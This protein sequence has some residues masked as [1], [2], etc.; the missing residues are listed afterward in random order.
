MPVCDQPC[1]TFPEFRNFAFIILCIFFKVLPLLDVSLHSPL[2]NF[3]HFGIYRSQ[4]LMCIIPHFYFSLI[5]VLT[6][7]KC[8]HMLQKCICCHC[9]SVFPDRTVMGFACSF[10]RWQTFVWS[11]LSLFKKKKKE[12]KEK[13]CRESSCSC[14]QAPMSESVYRVISSFLCSCGFFLAVFCC[15]C[16]SGFW[17]QCFMPVR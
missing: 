13:G 10:S 5:E 17:T 15:C 3:A 11:L 9:P 2:L 8:W 16:N 7:I 12:R 4:T 14:L 6:S 1:A